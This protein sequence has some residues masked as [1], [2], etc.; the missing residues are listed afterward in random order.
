MSMLPYSSLNKL[1]KGLQ[2]S[3]NDMIRLYYKKKKKVEKSNMTKTTPNPP[4]TFPAYHEY[5]KVIKMSIT[6]ASHYQLN[7][8]FIFIPTDSTQNFFW[9][10]SQTVKSPLQ[11]IYE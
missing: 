5:I 4:T 6:K 8:T 1:W 2:H 7:L 3:Q 10:S 11:G 9:Q